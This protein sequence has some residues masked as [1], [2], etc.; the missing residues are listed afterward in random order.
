MMFMREIALCSVTGQEQAQ[1]THVQRHRRFPLFSCALLLT[2][3]GTSRMVIRT[4]RTLIRPPEQKYGNTDVPDGNKDSRTEIRTSHRR[5]ENG[6]RRSRLSRGSRT[7]IRTSRMVIWTPEFDVSK[8]WRI[9]RRK[10]NRII[11]FYAS[12][13]GTVQLGM[14]ASRASGTR[15]RT[16]GGIGG[17]CRPPRTPPRSKYF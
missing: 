4:S 10:L 11:T 2:E 6:Q 7:Q 15:G 14:E 17:G 13:L 9:K 5:V 3:I 16:R 1:L 8:Q 12:V